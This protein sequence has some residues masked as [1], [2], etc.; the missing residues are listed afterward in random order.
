MICCR[1]PNCTSSFLFLNEGRRV[2]RATLCDKIIL[3]II[4]FEITFRFTHLLSTLSLPQC[5]R[6]LTNLLRRHNC[7][8][9]ISSGSESL[10]F[11]FGL[12]FFYL[13]RFRRCV[14]MKLRLAQSQNRKRK[15]FFHDILQR[16][17][18]VL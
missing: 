6:N 2:A 17:L 4:L 7:Q 11:H 10:G 14:S 18:V 5:D 8:N 12:S 16:Y 3:T 15:R 1:K 9:Q 13:P